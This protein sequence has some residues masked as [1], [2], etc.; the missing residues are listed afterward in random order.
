MQDPTIEI[1]RPSM[2]EAKVI[3]DKHSRITLEPFERGFGY[4]LG[5]ALRRILLSSMPGCAV[6]EVRIDGVLHEY[7]T[8]E[9]VRE[10]VLDILLNLKGLVVK[11]LPRDDTHTRDQAVL[12]LK[13]SGAG[14]VTAADIELVDG[15]EI[16]NPDHHIAML[17]KGAKLKMQLT[18]R[19]D[20]GYATAESR[21]HDDD[22]S[23]AVGTISLDASFSPINKVSYTVESARVGQRTDMDRLILDIITN[24]AIKPKD[25]VS[26]AATILHDQ[27]EVFVNFEESVVRQQRRV[28]PKIPPILLKPVAE[29]DLTMRSANCLKQEHIYYIG[30]L[31]Q[32]TETELMRTPNLGRKSLTEIKE[33]LAQHDLELGAQLENWPPMSFDSNR[34]SFGIGM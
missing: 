5:N 17:D 23:R 24:G 30:D 28:E 27:I 33:V 2:V 1:I 14:P 15:V 16:I 12:T 4:T 25:A 34:G 13:K 3:N 10:D 32:R 18:V 22:E 26:R 19:R 31:V 8:V 20:R 29:L 6:T 21:S 7:S 11:M 9:G